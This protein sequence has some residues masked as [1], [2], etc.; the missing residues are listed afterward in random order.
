FN[1]SNAPKVVGAL[2]QIFTYSFSYRIPESRNTPGSSNLFYKHPLSLNIS[3]YCRL[4]D[5]DG[6]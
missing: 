3:S 2:R 1:T 6:N 5:F 4:P